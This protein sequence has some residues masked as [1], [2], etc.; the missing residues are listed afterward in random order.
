[1]FHSSDTE[2]APLTR[3]LLKA[4]I[5]SWCDRLEQRNVKSSIFWDITPCSPLRVNRPA[6]TLVFA[7]LIIRPWR[8]RRH[9]P[10]KSRLALKGLHGVISQKKECN[11]SLLRGVGRRFLIPLV[12]ATRWFVYM[13]GFSH[14]GKAVRSLSLRGISLARAS[15]GDYFASLHSLNEH[16]QVHY[17]L[18]FIYITFDTNALLSADFVVW[19]NE[20]SN[21]VLFYQ[22]SNKGLLSSL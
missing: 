8:W 20:E 10:P 9:V 7:W 22:E 16:T 11:R 17:N 15:R 5:S 12:D 21:T 13:T 14:F 3:A 18:R 6:F 1:M 2:T 4:Q 19:F